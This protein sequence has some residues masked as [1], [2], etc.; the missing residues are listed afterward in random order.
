MY[1]KIGTYLLA[2]AGLT[3]CV[4]ESYDGG[5][6]D[7]G[8]VGG[9]I[10]FNNLVAPYTRAGKTGKDAADA[11]GSAFYVYG[12]KNEST[13]GSNSLTSD[14]LVFQNYKVSYKDGSAN[15]STSNSA[16]WEY[17]GNTLSTNEQTNVTGNNG[18]SAQL[19]KYWDYNAKNYTF[20]AFAVAGN[21]LESGNIKVAKTTTHASDIYQRGY[22]VTMT[23]KADPANLY[24]ADRMVIKQSTNTDQAQSNQY[25]GQVKFSFRNAMAKVR[26]GMYETIPGYSLTIDAFRVADDAAPSFG[27]MT[28]ERTDSFA[29]NLPNNK[30]GK[31]GTA[32]IIYKDSRTSDENSPVVMFDAKKDNIL[33]LGTNLKK[34][35]TAI[36][37]TATNPTYDQTDGAYTAVYPMESNGSSLKVNVDF[38]L[39]ATTGETIEVKNATAEVPAA[40][41]KWHPGYAYTYLFKISDQTNATIGKLTGLYPITFDAV[42]ISNGTGQEEEISTMGNGVN[43]I[44][45]G[46]DPTTKMMT[47]GQ[48]DYNAGNTIYASTIENNS[49]VTT[50]TTNTKL[51]IATTSDAENNP[52][53]E[54]NVASYLAEYADDANLVDQ[55]VTVYAQPLTSDDNIV[56]MVPMGD[57]TDGTRSLSA[58]KWTADKHVYAV[59]YT[60]DAKNKYYKIV[61][62]D[63][64]N[65]RSTGTLTLSSAAVTNAGA[66]ITP[67]LTVDGVTPSNAQVS[68][69]LDYD[70]TYG[71][72]VPNG[73]T[74]NDDKTDGVTITVPSQT[75]PT[76][77]GS[78]YTVIA[79]YNRRTYRA[80]FT[81]SQ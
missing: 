67:T 21:D 78:K 12:I 24:L 15:S 34:S 22:T 56:A 36:G 65:G 10:S 7:T 46:Y 31:A 64:Y 68:Y 54:A 58:V 25:G 70:G 63:G 50:T 5:K 61:R 23:D 62:V 69:T 38:T 66:T 32:T 81:V 72:A 9:A 71:Q 14:N 40:Y 76:T 19:I 59:E 47:T 11:L 74:V 48:D 60:K 29:A 44:S 2:V 51:Y 16:G 35:T 17:V 53:T 42:K 80:T 41:L 18:G 13:S 43:I 77:G 1:R 57:G 73:V 52:I 39:H 33:V 45:M 30:K 28:T 37:T 55:P 49:V 75:D 6:N 4:D 8:G 20:Y 27:T 26:V 3:A 79:T